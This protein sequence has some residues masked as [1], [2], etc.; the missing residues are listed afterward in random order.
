MNNIY[1]VSDRGKVARSFQ[2]IRVECEAEFQTIPSVW[3]AS[4]KGC[5]LLCVAG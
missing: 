5:L 3:V 2:C 1:S 4:L